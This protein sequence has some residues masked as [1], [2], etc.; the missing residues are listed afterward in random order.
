MAIVGY[1]L[2]VNGGATSNMVIDV[3]LVYSY[4]LT[5]LEAATEYGVEILAYNEEGDESSYS[6]AVFATT[7]DPPEFAMLVD[8]DAVVDDDG[9]SIADL[10]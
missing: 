10:F 7:F 2:R 3:G 1:R 9:E 8:G 5:G 6:T 4:A